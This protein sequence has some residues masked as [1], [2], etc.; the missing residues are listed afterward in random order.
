MIDRIADYLG[1]GAHAIEDHELDVLQDIA[2][3]TRCPVQDVSSRLRLPI[4]R[5]YAIVASLERQGFVRSGYEQEGG[6]ERMM[7][8]ITPRGREAALH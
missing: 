5:T 2:E 7:A 1:R 4:G 3:R 8:A 6:R